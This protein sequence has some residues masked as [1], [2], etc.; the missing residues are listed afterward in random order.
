VTGVLDLIAAA[1]GGS[2]GFGG[3]GGGGG[4][5]G[6]GD[7]DGDPVFVLIVLAG[8]ALVFLFGL[9]QALRARKRRPRRSTSRS[10]APG[11]RATSTVSRSS[12]A[13]T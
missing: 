13:R 1:G 10:S 3:G 11:T 5:S 6:G 8:F 4:F 9:V 12:P 2:S 7:D